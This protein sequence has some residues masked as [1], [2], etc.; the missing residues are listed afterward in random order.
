MVGIADLP[1]E[2]I[3]GLKTSVQKSNAERADKAKAASIASST[4]LTLSK[5]STLDST[6]S[7]HSN[8]NSTSSESAF[9]TTTDVTDS[10]TIDIYGNKMQEK[11]IEMQFLTP[12]KR[13]HTI[14]VNDVHKPKHSHTIKPGDSHSHKATVVAEEGVRTLY[15]TFILSSYTHSISIGF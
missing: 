5:Q 6:V 14:S 4:D 13:S 8:V 1:V 11:E 10:D 2:I 15:T 3:T 12:E 7:G 9:A